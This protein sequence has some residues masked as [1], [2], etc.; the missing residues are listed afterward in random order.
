MAFVIGSIF[1]SLFTAAAFILFRSPRHGLSVEQN[2]RLDRA[3]QILR[4]RHAEVLASNKTGPAACCS[5]QVQECPDLHVPR[6]ETASP[7][8]GSLR[9]G[10]AH[11]DETIYPPRTVA[12]LAAE[13]GFRENLERAANCCREFAEATNS[14]LAEQDAAPLR[15]SGDLYRGYEAEPAAHPVAQP[16]A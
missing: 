13:Q 11:V 16:C 8:G 5:V 9:V 2:A 14:P 7:P 1:G 6:Y 4:E 3:D 15:V 10:V 12:D